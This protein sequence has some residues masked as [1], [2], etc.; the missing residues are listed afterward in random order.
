MKL[1]F[2]KS[3]NFLDEETKYLENLGYNIEYYSEEINSGDVFSYPPQI[4]ESSKYI[5]SE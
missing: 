3:Y 1:I 4:A 5:S 2:R